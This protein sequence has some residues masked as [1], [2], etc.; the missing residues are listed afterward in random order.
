[1]AVIEVLLVAID[2]TVGAIGDTVYT[3]VAAQVV[4]VLQVAAT[5]AVALT[6][7]NLVMQ[8]I[9]MTLANG[10]SLMFRIAL[11]FLFV[12]SYGNFDAVY[13]A[14]ADTPSEIGAIVLSEVKGATVT[15]LYEGIDELYDKAIHV[16]QLFDLS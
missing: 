15:N 2:D 3:S 8:T 10:F 4:P 7:I 13:G 5:V 11:I 6:G 16:G 1:M 9:P 14:I 12:E